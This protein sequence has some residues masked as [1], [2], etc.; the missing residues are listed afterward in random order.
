VVSN[1]HQAGLPPVEAG[2]VVAEKALQI[3]QLRAAGNRLEQMLNS[4]KT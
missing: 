2:A 1:I 3:L 4:G